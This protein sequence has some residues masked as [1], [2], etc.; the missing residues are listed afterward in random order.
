MEHVLNKL[1]ILHGIKVQTK[2]FQNSKY[3]FWS[4]VY[5]ASI[6]WNGSCNSIMVI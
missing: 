3:P 2:N 6:T 5:H 1:K 4:D